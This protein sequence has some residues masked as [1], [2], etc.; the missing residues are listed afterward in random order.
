MATQRRDIIDHHYIG[1]KERVIN[2]FSFIANEVQEIL[3]KLGVPDLE[4]IMA[5][6]SILKDI[7]QDNSTTENI[8][9]S[10]I[11][12]SDKKSHAPHYCNTHQM[13]HGIKRI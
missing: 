6:H 1:E 13:I 9:L 10:P 12:Y 5:K 2:Y 8:D 7:T 11:L 3:V 4:S